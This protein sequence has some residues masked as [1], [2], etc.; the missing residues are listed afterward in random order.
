MVPQLFD[1]GG[2]P[3]GVRIE[4][5]DTGA[6]AGEMA[7]GCTPESARATRND[8]GAAVER[9]RVSFARR[10]AVDHRVVEVIARSL[11]GHPK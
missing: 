1:E 9:Q 7:R 8:R 2:G 11:P 5:D 4:Y 3:V 6:Q 10:R